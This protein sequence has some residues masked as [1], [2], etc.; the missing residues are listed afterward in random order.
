MASAVS[1]RPKQKN[2]RIGKRPDFHVFRIC[3]S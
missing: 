1:V 2:S 3:N